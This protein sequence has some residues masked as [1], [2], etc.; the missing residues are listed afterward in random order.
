MDLRS[1]SIYSFRQNTHQIAQKTEVLLW[2]DQGTDWQIWKGYKGG[3]APEI[4][5]EGEK[6]DR[7]LSIG[8]EKTH[9][10]FGLGRIHIFSQTGKGE[11]DY[12]AGKKEW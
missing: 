9:I 2:Q 8:Q 5:M 3:M 11:W 7:N 1:L 10:L 6:E 12:F 4:W